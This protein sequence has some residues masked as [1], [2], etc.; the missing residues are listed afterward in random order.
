[1]EGR[2]HINLKMPNIFALHYS[3]EPVSLYHFFDMEI[4]ELMQ[5]FYIKYLS[6][7]GKNWIDKKWNCMHP[8]ELFY[9]QT[10]K[11]QAVFS[12]ASSPASAKQHK[13]SSAQMCESSQ[14]T[15][16]WLVLTA[17]GTVLICDGY[18]DRRLNDKMPKGSNGCKSHSC[19]KT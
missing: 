4:L 14:G 5:W 13:G 18:F 17:G 1:M 2:L 9:E 3:L 8:A 12:P 15:S 11:L 16:Q 19:A 7:S 6:P 10:K